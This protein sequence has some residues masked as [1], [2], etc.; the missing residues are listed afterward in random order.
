MSD[1]YPQSAREWAKILKPYQQTSNLRVFVE[2]AIT[3]VPFLT[4]T[5]F[6]LAAVYAGYYAALLLVIPAAGFLVRLFILQHDCGHQSLFS[7]TWL[8]DWTG[9]AIG[10][11]TFTPYEYWRHNH[12]IHH[13]GCGNLEHRGVGDINTLTVEEFLERSWF[14]RLIYRVYRHPIV[15]F[16]IGPAYVFLLEQRIPVGMMTRGWK[17]WASTMGTNFFMVVVL[18]LVVWATS[19]QTALLVILP[20]VFFAASIGVWLFFVQHQF[21]ETLWDKPPEWERQEAA[22]YGSS[23]YDLPPVLRWFSGN[24][25]VHHVHHLNSRI[26]FFHLP[27]ILKENPG[28]I[29]INKITL[30]ESLAMVKLTLWDKSK[31]KLVSFSDALAAA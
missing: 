25:G 21:E 15:L 12:A 16:V 23:H 27:K 18:S 3:L 10:V 20:T 24:I 29:G 8:N 31:R 17:P 7:Q 22:L 14:G 28:L 30:L 2:L 19:W 26:P 1:S 6:M 9:R 11:L 5:G 13:A 4:L